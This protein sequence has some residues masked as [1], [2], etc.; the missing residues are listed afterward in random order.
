[1]NGFPRCNDNNPRCTIDN[2]TEK[3]QR[4]YLDS[5]QKRKPDDLVAAVDQPPRGRKTT[6]QE[7]FEKLLQ[8]KCPWHPGANHAAIDCYNLRRTFRNP[9]N[10]KKNKSTDKE[11]KENDQEDKSHNSKMPR[12]PSTSSAKVTKSS[13]PGGNRNYYSKKLCLSSRRYHDH[14]D[15]WRSPSLSHEMI[16]GPAS[17]SPANSPWSWTWWWQ[18][19]SSPEYSSTAEAVSTSSSLAP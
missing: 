4:D 11:P 2:R 12:K 10:D 15:G 19:S 17:R 13:V 16:S 14:N 1:V 7:Q 5:S 18:S 9:S 8:K 3:S 6:T